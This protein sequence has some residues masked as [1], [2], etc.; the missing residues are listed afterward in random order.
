MEI[1]S[2]HIVAEFLCT[3]EALHAV[4]SWWV[5]HHNGSLAAHVPHQHASSYSG[6]KHVVLE[7]TKGTALEE[8]ADRTAIT[9]GALANLNRYR[10]G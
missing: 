7:F 5:D 4:K 3:H 8:R 6:S 1:L 10:W 2:V 9:I